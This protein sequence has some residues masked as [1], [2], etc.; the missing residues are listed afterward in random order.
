MFYALG[1]TYADAYHWFTRPSLSQA[2]SSF[3]LKLTFL[4]LGGIVHS[5]RLRQKYTKYA[6]ECLNLEDVF[7]IGSSPTALRWNNESLFVLAAQGLQHCILWLNR[8]FL[9]E[10]GLF[11]IRCLLVRSCNCACWITKLTLWCNWPL[12]LPAA[13]RRPRARFIRPSLIERRNPWW[14][15]TLRIQCIYIFLC[16][17]FFNFSYCHCSA[18]QLYFNSGDGQFHYHY[19]N[20]LHAGAYFELMFRDV[21]DAGFMDRRGVVVA[22]FLGRKLFLAK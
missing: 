4:T 10:V 1:F 13:T 14:A 6:G 21:E 9:L 12:L 5:A 8:I 15:N 19:L 17:I 20:D 7:A 11:Y 2:A 16:K 18:L 22:R 3:K